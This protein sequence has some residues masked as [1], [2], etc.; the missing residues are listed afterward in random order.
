MKKPNTLNLKIQEQEDG[1]IIEMKIEG[2]D[3]MSVVGLL[4]LQKTEIL[5]DLIA[6]QQKKKKSGYTKSTPNTQ[7]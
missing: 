3:P 4:E 5:T 2:F 1:L 7:A 6:T